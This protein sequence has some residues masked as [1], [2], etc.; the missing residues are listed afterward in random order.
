ML[1]WMHFEQRFGARE[2]KFLVAPGRAAEI[3]IWARERMNPDPHA[4]RGG[5]YRVT[6]LYFDTD[7]FDVF[8]G[9]GSYGRAK[10][11]VRRYD[12]A[13]NVFVERKMRT[14]SLVS[15]RRAS[16]V[17]D[18]MPGIPHTARAA[19]SS[20]GSRPGNCGRFARLLICVQRWWAGARTGRSFD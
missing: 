3:R 6:S 5:T 11:R 7:K 8:H 15:K 4:S 12:D 2:I 9:R 14:A 18:E 13:P 20:G 16:I 1:V 10:Y 17:L 19:G